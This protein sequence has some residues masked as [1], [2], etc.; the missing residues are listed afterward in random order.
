VFKPVAL[1]AA[2]FDPALTGKPHNPGIFSDQHI[3]WH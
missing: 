1:V 2:L 3:L